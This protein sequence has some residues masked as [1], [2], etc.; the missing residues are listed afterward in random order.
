MNKQNAMFRKINKDYF[1][2]TNFVQQLFKIYPGVCKF[3]TRKQETYD[4]FYY[5]KY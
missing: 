2:N 4:V 3:L 1:K 5:R